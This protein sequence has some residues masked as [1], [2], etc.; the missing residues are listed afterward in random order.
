MQVI[1]LSCLYFSS[2]LVD[3]RSL[4]VVQGYLS[5]NFQLDE[6]STLAGDMDIEHSRVA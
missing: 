2:F 1:V 5:C 4:S 3:I 6:A